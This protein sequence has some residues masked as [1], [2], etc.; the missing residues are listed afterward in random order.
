MPDELRKPRLAQVD[1][2]FILERLARSHR[3][4]RI[5]NDLQLERGISTTRQNIQGYEKRNPEI[6]RTLREAFIKS[7]GSNPLIEK[8]ERIT[9]LQKMYDKFLENCGDV[10]SEENIAVLSGL[11]DQIRKEVEPIKIKGEG[12]EHSETFNFYEFL[13]AVN[14]G[15]IIRRAE[16]IKRRANGRSQERFTPLGDRAIEN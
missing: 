10:F 4:Q 9:E 5:V 15:D 3:P 14:N 1:R 8:A 12:F 16:D 6:I 7:L 2:D 11:I 13:G